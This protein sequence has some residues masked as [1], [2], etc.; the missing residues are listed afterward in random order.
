M[1]A[2]S[3][4]FAIYAEHQAT[5]ERRPL[6]EHVPTLAE[7]QAIARQERHTHGG[8]AGWEIIVAVGATANQ[9]RH[10]YVLT[11]RG[12]GV[13]S[14]TTLAAPD[15]PAARGAHAER[16]GVPVEDVSIITV[17]GRPVG[18]PF[19]LDPAEVC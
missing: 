7:A 14:H 13:L 18:G 2:T 6:A 17:D 10:S 1:D 15:A 12:G 16:A 5:A 3:I 11:H 4:E 19:G 9:P 8:C